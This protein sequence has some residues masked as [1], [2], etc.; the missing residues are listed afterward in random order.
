MRTSPECLPCFM[1]QAEYAAEVATESISLRKEVIAAS[2]R[3]IPTFDLSLSPPENSVFLYRKIGEL[4]GKDDVF[5]EL[6]K[7]SNKF[8]LEMLDDLRSMVRSSDDPFQ[9]AARLA[10]A[11]NV[12]DYGSHQEF[13]IDRTIDLCLT[14]DLRIND[15]QTFRQDLSTSARILYLADNCGELVFDRLLIEMI[16]SP[17]TVSVKKLPI[18]NDAL[19]SDAVVCGLTDHDCRVISNGTDCPGTPP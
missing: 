14:K 9:T 8:A 13:D 18:I 17:I 6:K 2:T 19:V 12:I 7:D 4:S 5:A 10:I 11:G 3:L 16:N 15:L 1:R